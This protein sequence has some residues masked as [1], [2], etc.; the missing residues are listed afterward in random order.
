M[1]THL[2]RGFTLIELLVVI[3]IIGVL[4]AL[5]LPAVQAAREAARRAQCTN[6]LKQLGL[7][8][9]NYESSHGA[10][11]PSVVLSGTGG[12]VSWFGN[13]GVHCRTLSVLEQ[14]QAFNAINFDVNNAY[15]APQNT[16]VSSLVVQTFLCPSDAKQPVTQHDFGQAA[17]TNYG[18]CM[19]DWFVW[20]GFGGPENRSAFGPNR[21]RRWADFRDGTSQTMLAAEVKLQQP[22]YRDCGGLTQ[23]NN[24]HAVP[25]PDADPYATA[26]EYLGTGSCAL[27]ATGHT[28]WGDGMVHQSGFTTAWTPNRKVLGTPD[29][30]TDMDITGKREKLGGPT[31]AAIT[32]RSYHPGGVNVLMGDGS[33]RFIKDS[34]AGSTWRGLETVS[35]GEVI[36]NDSL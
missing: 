1:K 23:V 15:E 35:G 33:V 27:K 16:T 14:A 36:S 12:T 29:R 5:L 2:R 18:F 9:H 19:G 22:Y 20:G 34:I 6:N 3:A 8:L 30:Q 7:G 31:F 13:W 24:P 32:A 21:S 26:P 11:P 25:P 10:L 28:E 4:I 17:G